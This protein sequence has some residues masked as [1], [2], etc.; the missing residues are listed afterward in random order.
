MSALRILVVD[1][2]RDFAEALSDVLACEGHEVDMC[3]TG[4]EAVER[5]R[6]HDYDIS[7]MDVTLPKQ[8]G[9]ESFLEIKSLK[10]DS[11]VVMMTGFSMEELLQQ[12]VDNGAWA[13]MHKPLEMP[14]VL[15]IV[16]RVLPA[17]V[18]LIADDDPEFSN[19]LR[20]EL[21]GRGFKVRLAQDGARAIEAIAADGIDLLILDM[22]MPVMDGLAVYLELRRRDIS[23]P[24]I[25]VTGHPV[26]ER[27]AIDTLRDMAVTGVLVK[28][29]DSAE[30]LQSVARMI[31][32]T[33][34]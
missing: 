14:E 6:D 30:L 28:P 16:E 22:K 31:N 11:R 5:F 8:N 9:V 18:V 17:G 20:E 12:A 25:I 2:D 1:D 33:S 32:P 10:P 19:A 15:E 24:T 3:H 4:E 23:L 29:F 26:D 7:F 27:S 34:S 21:E 13:V